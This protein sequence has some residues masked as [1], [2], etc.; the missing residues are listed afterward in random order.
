VEGEGALYVRVKDDIV[1]DVKFRIYEPPRFFEAL[2]RG[3]H[4]SEAPDITARICGICPVAYQLSAARA[5]EDAAGV[6][7]PRPLEDLRRLLYCGEW[8][9]SH[10]LHVYLLH[11]PDFLGYEDSFAVARDHPDVVRRGLALKHAGNAL[12]ERVG[13]RAVHPIN[14]RVGGF[15]RVPARDELQALPRAARAFSAKMDMRAAKAALYRLGAKF[16]RAGAL[17]AW[18][19]TRAKASDPHWRALFALPD[20]WTP[21]EFP[22]GGADLLGLGMQPGPE[23]GVVLRA[24]EQRWI[25]GEFAADRDALLTWARDLTTPD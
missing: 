18:S 15:H 12:I 10:A 19:Q 6:A 9:Q 1:Q 21:P 11:A 16:Y 8:L 23:V 2:L 3:R 25:E 24:V 7:L 22:L 4:F 5:I 20:E 14:V 17:L 13:G